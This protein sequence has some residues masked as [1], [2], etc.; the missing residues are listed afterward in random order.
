MKKWQSHKNIEKTGSVMAQ[1][2]SQHKLLIESNR[3]YIR[4]LCEV[5]LFLCRQGLVFRGH[6]EAPSSMN[7]GMK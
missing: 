3:R 2:S 6:N 1:V 4:A 5:T 7:H